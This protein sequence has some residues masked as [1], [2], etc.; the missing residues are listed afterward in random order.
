[1]F[2]ERFREG[3]TF[4]LKYVLALVVLAPLAVMVKE[5]GQPHGVI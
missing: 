1:M 2:L 4:L 3:L 5:A